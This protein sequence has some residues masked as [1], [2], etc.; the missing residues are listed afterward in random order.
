ME[1]QSLRAFLVDD[2]PAMRQVLSTLLEQR[3]IS[4]CA[5]ADSAH[6]ALQNLP[7][8]TIDL[9]VVDLSFEHDKGFDLIVALRERAISV[10][11]YSMHEDCGHIDRALAC[12][13]NAYISKRENSEDLIHGIEEAARGRDYLSPRIRQAIKNQPLEISSLPRCSERELQILRLLG[14]GKG[15]SEI[16]DTLDLSVRTIESY[17]ARINDK[18]GLSGMKELRQFTIRHFQSMEIPP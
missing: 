6:T 2:H 18:L 13:A 11:V 7:S 9:A 16:A 15:S 17:C 4:A 5:E 14:Q 3:G 10:V 12:G 8:L 1:Q